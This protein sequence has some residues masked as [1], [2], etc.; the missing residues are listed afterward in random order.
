MGSKIQIGCFIIIA[1]ILFFLMGGGQYSGEILTKYQGIE[2]DS[3]P[4]TLIIQMDKRVIFSHVDK[5]IY[6]IAS[7][8][9]TI[10][11]SDVNYE[12]Y[13]GGVP[14]LFFLS[15]IEI[16]LIGRMY[17]LLDKWFERKS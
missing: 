1:A 11:V 12:H 17:F 7:P 2:G 14:L 8:N 9:D 3:L 16:I 4:Y 13:F 10:K 6:D 15:F 5:E